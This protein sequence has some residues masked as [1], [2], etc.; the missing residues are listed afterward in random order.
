MQLYLKE[1][2]ANH[3]ST[4]TPRRYIYIHT[5]MKELK[6]KMAKLKSVICCAVNWKQ[7]MKIN[8]IADIMFQIAK[9]DMRT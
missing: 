8:R 1:L 3:T 2:V 9:L 4:L 7:I 5:H 6:K